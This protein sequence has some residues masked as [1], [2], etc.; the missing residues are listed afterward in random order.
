MKKKKFKW[1]RKISKLQIK[2]KKNEERVQ[3]S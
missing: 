3:L 2:K 1:L